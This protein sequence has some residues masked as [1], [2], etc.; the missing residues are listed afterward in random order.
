VS[1]FLRNVAASWREEMRSSRLLV[2]VGLA[3][4]A[5][6]LVGFQR[7]VSSEVQRD[8]AQPPFAGTQPLGA[9]ACE[10]LRD[11]HPDAPCTPPVD[12]IAYT[13]AS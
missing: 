2:L 13:P 1:A 3:L 4:A 6:M 8:H 12:A 9:Q 7:V 10:A 5:L 11:G